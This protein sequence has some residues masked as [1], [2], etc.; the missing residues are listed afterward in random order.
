M[1]FLLSLCAVL[2]IAANAHAA[3]ITYFNFGGLGGEGL[4][5]TNEVGGN[6]ATSN[7]SSS[8]GE[9]GD[10]LLYDSI[11]N[12]LSFDFAFGEDISDDDDDDNDIDF[13]FGDLSSALD[14]SI[15]GGIHFHSPADINGTAPVVFALNNNTQPNVTSTISSDGLS[16]RVSGFVTLEESME[17]DL[18]AGNFYLNIHSG[19][20]SAGE[21]RGNLQAVPEPSSMIV[22]ATGLFSIA[23]FAWFR[24]RRSVQMST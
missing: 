14:A 7:L 20:F 6:A 19:Q 21:L 15:A 3:H 23:A 24:K 1:R 13:G 16:G 22:L 9:I 10:S 11:L 2:A 8:G 5:P 17:A 4:L 18:L 12:Q